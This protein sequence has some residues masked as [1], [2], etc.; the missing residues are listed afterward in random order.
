[1][2]ARKFWLFLLLFIPYLALIFVQIG[3]MTAKVQQPMTANQA[4]KVTQ[5][6]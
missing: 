5:D 1:M 4:P 3:N 2:K 6:Q